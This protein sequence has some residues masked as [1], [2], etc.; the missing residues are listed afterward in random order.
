MINKQIIYFEKIFG[1][2]LETKKYDLHCQYKCQYEIIKAVLFVNQYYILQFENFWKKKIFFQISQ[3]F[4]QY[5]CSCWWIF[6][7][8]VNIAHTNGVRK[9]YESV[10]TALIIVQLNI[11][12]KRLTVRGRR[13]ILSSLKA[14]CHLKVHGTCT[15]I[16]Y[17]LIR[18]IG[19]LYFYFGSIVKGFW[20][21]FILY[22]NIDAFLGIKGTKW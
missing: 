13:M 5:D 1:G 21:F 9:I 11:L 12:I 15:D 14:I 6:Y 17:S 19:H 4:T 18:G 2:T 20:Y 22:K 16:P 8:L 10:Q 7:R 3:L